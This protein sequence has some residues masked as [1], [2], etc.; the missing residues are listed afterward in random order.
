MLREIHE[1]NEDVPDGNSSKNSGV[2][3]QVVRE[4]EEKEN[5][6]VEDNHDHGDHAPFAVEPR[7]VKADIFRLVAGP[8]DQQLRKI[9]IGQQHHKREKQYS[10]VMHIAQMNDARK[11]YSS[12]DHQKQRIHEI[13]NGT[14]L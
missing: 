3:H 5:K 14:D 10:Q 8:D 11:K 2:E 12:S 13:N 7:A 1:R 6:K 9:E 4:Q